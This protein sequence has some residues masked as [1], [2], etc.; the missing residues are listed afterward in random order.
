MGTR[1]DQ[2]EAHIRRF[3]SGHEVSKAAWLPGPAARRWPDLHCLAIAPG[4]RYSGWVYLSVGASEVASPRL[5]FILCTPYATEAAIEL[6]A[7]VTHYHAAEQLGLNHMLPIGRPWLPGA[8]CDQFF[9]CLPYPFGP[10]LEC[11][12]TTAYEVQA[13]WL[14]PVTSA[15]RA[16]AKQNGAEALE[17]LFD[18]NEI[19]PLDTDRASVV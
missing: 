10:D 2:I 18:E 1:H 5:E 14:L 15:E 12:P 11:I 17:S 16:F 8:T 19:D 4:P 9:V 13:L 7:M 3:F 6:L